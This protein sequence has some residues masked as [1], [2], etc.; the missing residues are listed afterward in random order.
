MALDIHQQQ[1]NE[2]YSRGENFIFYPKD[3]IVKFLNRFVRKKTGIDTF[4]DI[5]DFSKPVRGLDFGCGIGRQTILMREFGIDA[6]GYDISSQAIAEAKKLARH[7]GYD[8]L[9]DKFITGDGRIIPFD[10]AFFDVTISESTLDSMTFEL[11]KKAMAE[12]DRATSKIAFF[13]FIS[14]EVEGRTDYDGD[15]VVETEH[16]KGTI[17]GYYTPEKIRQ[18]L[19]GTNWKLQWCRLVQEKGINHQCASGRYYVVAVK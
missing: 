19:S 11:A 14:G 2:S 10:D 5:L 15:V 8:D 4:T 6:Y 9:I 7:L 1:W 3:E 17:Q 13:S 16:E 18:I 12:I